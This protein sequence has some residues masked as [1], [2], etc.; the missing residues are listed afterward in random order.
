MYLSNVDNIINDSMDM[1]AIKALIAH[2]IKPDNITA[3]ISRKTDS[4]T[5][6]Y[7]VF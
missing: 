4:S 6:M 3:G 5:C 7:F 2:G 1:H